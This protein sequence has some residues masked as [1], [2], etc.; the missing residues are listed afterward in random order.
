V[1]AASLMPG[2]NVQGF[3]RDVLT[4]V[5]AMG[6]P[7]IRWPGG[8]YA[9]CYDWRKAIGPRDQRPPVPFF[10][11]ANLSAMTTAWTPMTWEPMSSWPSAA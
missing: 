1:G 10:P 6:P 7:I 3:R 2:D 9:D 5:K 4:L 8:G 11:T